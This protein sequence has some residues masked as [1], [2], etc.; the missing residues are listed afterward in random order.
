MISGVHLVWAILV[1]GAAA[2]PSKPAQLAEPVTCLKGLDP[3]AL[4]QGKE[5]PGDGGISVV[6]GRY[7]YLFAD[8]DNKAVFEKQPD[9]YAIQLGGGCGRMGP[10]SGVGN[11]DRFLVHDG[12][13]YIFASDQCMN[14]FKAAPEKHIESDDPP[15]AGSDADQKRGQELVRQALAGFGGAAKVDAITSLELKRVRIYQSGGEDKEHATFTRVV[16]PDRFRLDDVWHSGSAADFVRGAA[17]YRIDIDGEWPMDEIVR[18]EFVKLFRRNPLVLLKARN[19]PGFHAVALGR[20]TLDDHEVEL[21]AIN[22]DGA[23]T[24][25]GIDPTTG[26]VFNVYYRGRSPSAIGDVMRTYSDF[27]NVDGIT[28][29][30]TVATSYKA[31]PAGEPRPYAAVIVNPKFDAKLFAPSATRGGP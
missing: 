20:A 17:G 24:T 5:L 7:R 30:F 28:I 14:G 13:I 10:L 25:L 18:R 29:P 12:R 1:S 11:P 6:R 21:L 9:R 23:T 22:L 3:V 27:R 19:E 31:V 8:A 4:T 15:P 16:F 2:A 26:R